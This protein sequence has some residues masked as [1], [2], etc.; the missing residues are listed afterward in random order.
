MLL[1]GRHT[2]AIV[3]FSS[4]KVNIMSERERARE[5]R[6]VADRTKENQTSIHFKIKYIIDLNINLGEFPLVLKMED[7][8]H[9]VPDGYFRP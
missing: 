7:S 1:F 6:K 4:P 5:T 3:G 8:F 9:K 2:K